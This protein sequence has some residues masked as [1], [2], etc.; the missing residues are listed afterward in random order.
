MLPLPQTLGSLLSLAGG[1]RRSEFVGGSGSRL[2]RLIDREI[3]G[4]VG[5]LS[6]LSGGEGGS[7][8][9]RRVD[10][11]GFAAVPFSAGEDIQLSG[12]EQRDVRREGYDAGV[13]VFATEALA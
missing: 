3:S 6:L 2:S 11:L 1:G 4:K 8:E 10:K 5:E 7:I 12:R 13:P 9:P